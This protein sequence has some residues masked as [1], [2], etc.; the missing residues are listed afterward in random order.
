MNGRDTHLDSTFHKKFEPTRKVQVWRHH[1]ALLGFLDVSKE[2]NAFLDPQ[3][4]K[5]EDS[6][7]LRNVTLLDPRKT[8]SSGFSWFYLVTADKCWDF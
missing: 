8:E 7:F 3:T 4:F 6:A 1:S 2:R 5:Q